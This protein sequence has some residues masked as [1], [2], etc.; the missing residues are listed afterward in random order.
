MSE[1]TRPAA[2]LDLDQLHLEKGSHECEDGYC[3]MEARAV[4]LGRR[5]SDDCPPGTSPVLHRFG[6]SLNDAFGDERRQELKRF[7]P[8]GGVDPLDGTAGDGQDEARGFLALDWLVRTYTPAF[9]DLRPEL[10]GVAADLRG[11]RRIVDMATA[12]AAGPVVRVAQVNARAAVTAAWDA[13][14]DAAGDAAGDAARDAAWAAARD[15]AGAAAGDAAWDAAGDALQPTV[16]QLQVSA[17]RL[18]EQLINPAVAIGAGET[19]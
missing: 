1:S 11:L 13:A 8:R 16:D 18:F 7:L 17:I 9:L 12:E 4:I 19:R 2:A 15:A 3:F 5:K 14:R 6:V 10:A